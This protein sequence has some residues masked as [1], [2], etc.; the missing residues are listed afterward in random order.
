MVYTK[1]GDDGTTS[2]VGGTRVKKYDIRVQ[3]YGEI[4]HLISLL[5]YTATHLRH[6]NYSGEIFV[7]Q[8]KLFEI[9]SMIACE[10]SETLSKV[11]HVTDID[12]QY[13]ERKID[14]M[15]ADIPPLK[16]FIIPSGSQ[17]VTL[18]NMAR[19]QTRRCE[20]LAVE[21]NE[22]YP[23]DPVVLKYLNRL[24]DYLFVLGRM[25]AKQ[26]HRPEK[27]WKAPENN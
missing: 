3:T 21:C 7:I 15:S 1:K 10:N 11:V 13:L 19:T 24:S 2:L 4:D 23:Q 6:D 25:I 9:E 5:G 16:N 14:T 8:C 26:K 27:F 17:T 22:Q 12:V 18:L 20:R